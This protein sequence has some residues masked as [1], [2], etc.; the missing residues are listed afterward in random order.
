MSAGNKEEVCFPRSENDTTA[1]LLTDT[2]RVTSTRP[3]QWKRKRQEQWQRQRGWQWHWQSQC[4]VKDMKTTMSI[5]EWQR[6]WL[7]I[8]N[9]TLIE[10]IELSMKIMRIK[11]DSFFLLV[12]RRKYSESPLG[13]EPQTFGFRAPVLC[14]WA[15]ETPRRAKSVTKFMWHASYILLGSAISIT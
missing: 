14:H 13:I 6:Q 10:T 5:T 1:P 15:T 9:I 11:K 12:T 4:N 8:K 3:L 2:E 7:M